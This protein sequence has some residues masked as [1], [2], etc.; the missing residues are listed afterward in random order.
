MK[1]KLIN[2]TDTWIEVT[3]SVFD[4]QEMKVYFNENL[5]SIRATMKIL[6]G[7]IAETEFISAGI[8]RGMKKSLEVLESGRIVVSQKKFIME[9]GL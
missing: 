8:K 2:T 1:L 6:S 4:S 3:K 7:K 5:V 9:E